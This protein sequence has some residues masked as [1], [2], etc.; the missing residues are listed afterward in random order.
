MDWIS[1]IIARGWR[2]GNPPSPFPSLHYNI[3]GKL[4]KKAVSLKAPPPLFLVSL[5]VSIS[6]ILF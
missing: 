6:N 4:K 5:L 3:Q 1:F 2:L